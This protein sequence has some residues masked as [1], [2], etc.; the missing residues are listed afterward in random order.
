MELAA[1]AAAANMQHHLAGGYGGH[2]PRKHPSPSGPHTGLSLGSLHHLGGEP[3]SLLMLERWSGDYLWG[4]L[5]EEG[6]MGA[7][8]CGKQVWGAIWFPLVEHSCVVVRNDQ[9]MHG[10]HGATWPGLRGQACKTRVEGAIHL[11]NHA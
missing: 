5:Q 4:V 7:L 3:V 10:G 2:L 1:A 11:L 6:A 9:V 8:Y